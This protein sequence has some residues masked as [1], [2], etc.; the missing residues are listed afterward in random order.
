MECNKAKCI[1]YIA[2][3]AAL[4]RKDRTIKRLLGTLIVACGINAA[5]WVCVWIKKG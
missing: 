2:H 1:P 3:E 4:V 5:A